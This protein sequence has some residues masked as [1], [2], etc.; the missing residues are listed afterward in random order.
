MALRTK[1][2]TFSVSHLVVIAFF[3]F[4]GSTVH[5]AGLNKEGTLPVSIDRHHRRGD[6]DMGGDESKFGFARMHLPL[7]C[8]SFLK[9]TQPGDRRPLSR[10]IFGPGAGNLKKERR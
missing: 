3:S 5:Q 7:G 6:Q 8:R 10:K 2:N 9:S 4:L 1:V